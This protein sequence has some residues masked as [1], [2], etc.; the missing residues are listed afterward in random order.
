MTIE[1][2]ARGKGISE[3]AVY[4]RIRKH[5]L[6]VSTLKD[7]KTG[8]FT[9]EGEQL[10]RELFSLQAPES[11]ADPPGDQAA[12]PTT[13][14]ATGQEAAAEAVE[15]EKG[16]PSEVEKLRAEVEKFRNQVEKALNRIELLEQQ[17]AALTEERDFLRLSLE[18]AQQLQAITASKIPNPPPALPAGGEQAEHGFRAW[19]KRHFG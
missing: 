8:Q 16:E 7:R 12:E 10:L 13:A 2:I 4:K 19:W 15:V 9:P 6:V 11:P 3:Q 17:N 18:R 1:D 14:E 5:G